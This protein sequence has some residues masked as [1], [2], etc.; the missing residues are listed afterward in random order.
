MQLLGKMLGD[1]NKKELNHIQPIIDQIDA[2]A[3]AIKKLSDKELAAKTQEF[4]SQL[5]L[6]LKGGM[7]LEDELV[8]IFREALENIEPFAAKC[9]NAQLHSSLTEQRRVIE[10]RRDPEHMLKD[11]LQDTLSE[12]FENAYE[13][14]NPTLNT[15]RVSAAMDI[16]EETQAWPDE[17]DDPHL[18]TLALLTKVEPMLTEIDDD[19]LDEAFEQ[20][21][22]LF[23][24]AR[25]QAQNDEEGADERLESLLTNILQHLQGELVALKAEAIDKLI[26]AMAKRYKTGKTLDD[27][28]PEAFAV[29]REVGWRTIQMRHYDVQMIGGFVLHQGKIAEMKTGEGKTLVATLS[30]YLNALTG[31][32]VHIVTVNDYLAQRD[33]DWMGRIY[34]FLGLT[35]GV[36]MSQM[37]HDL[38]PAA[39]AADI[40]YGT[41]NEFGVDYLR[42]NLVFAPSE[43]VQ[44]GLHYAIVDEVDSILIDEA[45]TPL[46]ISGQSD[47]NVD[48]YYRLNELAP[49]LT[50]QAEEKG[51]GDCWLDE[52]AHQV[53]LSEDGHVNAEGILRQ[54]GLLP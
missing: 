51:P 46:I 36:N 8:N 31:R 49:K 15:L 41:N 16:A 6:Y 21:W 29:V 14:L 42:D 39:Y 13:N 44:R 37:S 7:V 54:A 11:N 4:R 1:P 27:L 17:A 47:D 50:R 35:V 52:K 23:E 24:E 30:A 32:G 45:R 22:P 48:L 40:T 2:F 33:A 53:L 25:Q 12:C 20:A 3:P 5:Y 9:S 26:P 34:R 38:K 19:Y 10:R 43:R 18:A 28:L